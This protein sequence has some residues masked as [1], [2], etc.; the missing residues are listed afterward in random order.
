MRIG[1]EPAF[2]LGDEG[3]KMATHESVSNLFGSKKGG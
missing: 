3:A 1:G 2:T